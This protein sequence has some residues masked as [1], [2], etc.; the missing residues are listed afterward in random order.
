MQTIITNVANQWRRLLP[1]YDLYY[2]DTTP[3][4]A[5]F[6]KKVMAVEAYLDKIGFLQDAATSTKEIAGEVNY[7]MSYEVIVR[8]ETLMA[9]WPEFDDD[10]LNQPDET[11]AL[12]SVTAHR[13]CI[14]YKI[15]VKIKFFCY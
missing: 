10:L 15:K 7:S 9:S 5:E 1:A 11:I 3:Q 2:C 14:T 12:W 6:E 4:L 13:V 8:D